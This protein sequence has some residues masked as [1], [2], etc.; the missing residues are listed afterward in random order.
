M[1]ELWKELVR[2]VP[3]GVVL[4]VMRYLDIKEKSEERRE[5]DA[6]AKEKAEQDRQAQITISQTYASAINNMNKVFEIS[7]TTLDGS[8]KEFKATVLEQYRKLGITQ[9]VMDK[10]TEMS[11][12][13]RKKK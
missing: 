7:F 11:E 4:I 9:D 2:S 3:W 1:D 6:N 10:M 12:M 13:E 5:R 8:I